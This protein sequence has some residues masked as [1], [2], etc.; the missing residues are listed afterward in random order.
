MPNRMIPPRGPHEGYSPTQS[1]DLFY[2]KLSAELA[3]LFPEVAWLR[4]WIESTPLV[5]PPPSGDAASYR[6]CY[7]DTCRFV[8]VAILDMFESNPECVDMPPIS[9]LVNP[10]AEEVDTALTRGTDLFNLYRDTHPYD[11]AI[12]RR[13]GLTLHQWGW[14]VNAVRRIMETPPI[15]FPGYDGGARAPFIDMTDHGVAVIPLGD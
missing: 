2:G 15:A 3:P 12:L 11:W 13:V 1:L 9:A 4:E 8:A 7:D 14:A 6:Q 5:V 10:T